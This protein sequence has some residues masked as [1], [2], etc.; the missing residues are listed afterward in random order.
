MFRGAF[1]TFLS[2]AKTNPVHISHRIYIILPFKKSS[3]EGTA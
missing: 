2:G 3:D 1:N